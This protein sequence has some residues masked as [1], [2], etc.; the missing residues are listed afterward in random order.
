MQARG[1]TH[2]SARRQCRP[3]QGKGQ[4]K[5]RLCLVPAQEK[6]VLPSGT[7]CPCAGSIPQQSAHKQLVLCLFALNPQPR[8]FLLGLMEAGRHDAK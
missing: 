4:V 5:E 8:E 1:A 2:A 3:A 6:G 7:A